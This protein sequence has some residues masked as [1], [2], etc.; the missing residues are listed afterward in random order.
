MALR[1]G[2]EYWVTPG[3]S[4]GVARFI[5]DNL[6]TGS[7]VWTASLRLM[8]PAQVLGRLA[9]IHVKASQVATAS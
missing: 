3:G 1:A 5:R 9:V 7:A 2:F 8:A 6:I 4:G